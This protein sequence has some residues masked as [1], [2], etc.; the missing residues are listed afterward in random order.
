MIDKMP[1]I[2]PYGLLAKAEE[3]LFQDAMSRLE[4]YVM[5][6]L[7]SVEQLKLSMKNEQDMTPGY[8]EKIKDYFREKGIKVV[9]AGEDTFTMDPATNLSRYKPCLLFKKLEE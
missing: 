2:F 4:E 1:K 9:S 8:V 6:R 3:F 5:S 7:Q